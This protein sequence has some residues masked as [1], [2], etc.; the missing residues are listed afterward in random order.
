MFTETRLS[1]K[2]H[3]KKVCTELNGIDITVD[4]T[5]MFHVVIRAETELERVVEQE[6]QKGGSKC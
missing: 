1:R 2:R 6:V 3:A 4:L 5:K